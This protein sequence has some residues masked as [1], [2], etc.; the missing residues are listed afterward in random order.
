MAS[1]KKY[2]AASE[3]VNREKKYS[4]DEAFNILPELKIST[5]MDETV[6]LAIRLGVDPKHA[7]QMV[8]GA[9]NLPHGTGKTMRV[10]VFAKGDKAKEAVEAGADAVGAEDLSDR[11]TKEN[12]M[13]FD[14]VVATPDMMGVVGKLGR[15]L[16]PRG[17]MPNPKVGT[18]TADV[19][20]AVKELKGGRVE[21]KAEKAGVVH[22]RIGKMSFGGAKLR[23]NAWTLLEL[24]QKLKPSSAKG[25]YMKSIAVSSTMG[26]SVRIDVNEIVAKFTT[27]E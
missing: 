2:R 4:M 19:A 26:P 17:L 8:R 15:V 12:W 7:D 16:G 13:D 3:K 25:T 5:K 21:F 24:I 22:A 18:V 27:A 10:I 23:D 11:I 14:S 1:G 6:D 20:K 9:V